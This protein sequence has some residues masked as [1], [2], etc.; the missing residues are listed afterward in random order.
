MVSRRAWRIFTFLTGWKLRILLL[1]D[2]FNEMQPFL[3]YHICKIKGWGER[4]VYV[5][6]KLSI[7]SIENNLGSMLC[8]TTSQLIRQASICCGSNFDF[9]PPPPAAPK[10]FK[11]LGAL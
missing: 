5:K 1:L 10:F 8:V 11:N 2:L 7:L 9:L 4:G 3:A 6:V